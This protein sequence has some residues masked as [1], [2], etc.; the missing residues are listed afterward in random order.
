M[1]GSA[2]MARAQVVGYRD[3]GRRPRSLV[4]SR[5]VM[6]S[7]APLSERVVVQMDC[8]WK[9]RPE[10]QDHADSMNFFSF[11]PGIIPGGDRC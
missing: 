1:A 6:A 4:H 11:V 10:P 5:V 8:D 7:G 3:A 9:G 2:L